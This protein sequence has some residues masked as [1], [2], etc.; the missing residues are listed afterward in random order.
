MSLW[1][2]L[3]ITH[4]D[5]LIRIDFGIFVIGGAG[6]EVENRMRGRKKLAWEPQVPATAWEVG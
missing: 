1:D 4:W 3:F 2:G 6:G 5:C